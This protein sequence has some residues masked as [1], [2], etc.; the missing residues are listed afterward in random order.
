M[1]GWSFVA[2]KNRGLSI[3]SLVFLT[4]SY[5]VVV[6]RTTNVMTEKMTPEG[7]HRGDVVGWNAA[8]NIWRKSKWRS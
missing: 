1:I 2:T 3:H 7:L 5:R 4:L 8:S 6:V